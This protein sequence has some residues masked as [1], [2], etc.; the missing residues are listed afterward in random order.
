MRASRINAAFR[1][2]GER[3]TSEELDRVGRSRYA[4]PVQMTATE[5]ET[6][7]TETPRAPAGCFVTTHWSVVL[8]AGRS[9]TPR[10]QAALEKLCRGY[11]FPLYAY[12]RRRGHSVEDAQDLT[13]TI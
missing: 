11:W 10:A 8:T 12:V 3:H 13:R 1:A 6:P 7:G 5:R 4:R 9:D 2:Q